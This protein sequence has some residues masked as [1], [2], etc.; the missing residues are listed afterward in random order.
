MNLDVTI[1]CFVV[2]NDGVSDED[3]EVKVC[4]LL[5]ID[6]IKNIEYAQA[7]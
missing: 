6:M 3:I 7:A 2:I 5:Q 1:Q 4:Q